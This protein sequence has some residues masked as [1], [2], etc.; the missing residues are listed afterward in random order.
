MNVILYIIV[1][2]GILILSNI[3]K[4]ILIY[5]PFFLLMQVSIYLTYVHTG[6]NIKNHKYA[7]IDL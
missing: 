3:Y 5:F 4:D 2:I 6:Y 7:C 1:I